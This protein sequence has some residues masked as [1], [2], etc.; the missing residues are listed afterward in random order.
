MSISSE[1]AKHGAD[2]SQGVQELRNCESMLS[3]EKVHHGPEDPE[4]DHP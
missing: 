4:D 1:E 3:A 2:R